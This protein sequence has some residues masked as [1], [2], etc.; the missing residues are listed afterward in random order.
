M[1]PSVTRSCFSLRGSPRLEPFCVV[2]CGR[3]RETAGTVELSMSS[4]AVVPKSTTHKPHWFLVSQHSRLHHHLCWNGAQGCLPWMTED[5]L[6]CPGCHCLSLAFP[7]EPEM[8]HFSLMPFYCLC[9]C[10]TV[11]SKLGGGEN[12]EKKRFAEV[13]L[14]P[15]DPF[16]QQTKKPKIPVFRAPFII[17]PPFSN[18][19]QPNLLSR[20]RPTARLGTALRV[21]RPTLLHLAQ[22]PSFGGICATRNQFGTTQLKIRIVFLLWFISNINWFMKCAQ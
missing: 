3:G 4:P 8:E 7:C 13:G 6:P 20:P 11:I 5:T 12:W 16:F 15:K 22:E 9:S 1:V 17:S 2:C 18:H 14:A 19:L 21:T 10:F